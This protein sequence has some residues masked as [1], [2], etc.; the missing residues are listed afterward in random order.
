MSCVT[1]LE[2]NE[3]D[4]SVFAKECDHIQERK[5]V[6]YK[7]TSTCT[8][9]EKQISKSKNNRPLQIDSGSLITQTVQ[10]TSKC[11]RKGVIL[12]SQVQTDSVPIGEALNAG[13]ISGETHLENNN[14][15]VSVQPDKDMFQEMEKSLSSQDVCAFSRELN[16]FFT[17][18]GQDICKTSG[19]LQMNNENLNTSVE[20]KSDKMK[21]TQKQ[22][23][24]KS[25]NASSKEK[26]TY[27]PTSEVKNDEASGK[28]Q[29]EKTSSNMSDQLESENMKV[30]LENFNGAKDMQLSLGEKN[31]FVLTKELK[32]K[33]RVPELQTDNENRNTSAKLKRKTVQLTQ[34]QLRGKDTNASSSG[35]KDS[36]FSTGVKTK[37]A[38]E[39]NVD[40][41]SN[42]MLDQPKNDNPSE[43]QSCL[44]KKIIHDSSKIGSKVDAHDH[45]AAMLRRL[46]TEFARQSS[47]SNCS[48]STR[49]LQQSSSRQ[50]TVSQSSGN[51]QVAIRQSYNPRVIS[52]LIGSKGDFIP[53]DVI[54]AA[55]RLLRNQ[56]TN[57]LFTIGDFTPAVQQIALQNPGQQYF[58]DD[59]KIAINFL[60]IISIG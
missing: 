28:L 13:T 22:P 19:E 7:D 24:D 15:I 38:N 8:V 3:I 33:K 58:L 50:A 4:T 39:Q 12:A 36:L 30:T 11:T 25:I 35:E 6:K 51:Q 31:N 54:T 52:N 37:K 17:S 45:E 57:N 44:S 60:L 18:Q 20:L 59:D 1:E 29:M 43:M 47:L 14:E 21:V 26:N 40:Y 23:S 10:V 55:I 53:D 46:S 56:D 16:K 48:R 49:S 41:R 5:N 27:S 2:D 9:N 32:T 42:A 34:N